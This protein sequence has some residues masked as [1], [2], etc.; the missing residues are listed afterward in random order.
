MASILTKH[1]MPGAGGSSRGQ[2]LEHPL[3]TAALLPQA[4][5]PGPRARGAGHRSAVQTTELCSLGGR[6]DCRLGAGPPSRGASGTCPDLPEV[7]PGVHPCVTELRHG[8]A[9]PAGQRSPAPGTPRPDARPHARV[10]VCATEPEAEDGPAGGAARTRISV[11]IATWTAPHRAPARRPRPLSERCSEWAAEK[12]GRRQ[13]RTSPPPRPRRP[14]GQ[15][16]G[17]ALPAAQPPACQPGP[18]PRRRQPR[19][20]RT[21][22]ESRGWRRDCRRQKSCCPSS[23]QTSGGVWGWAVGAPAQQPK[24]GSRGPMCL[25]TAATPDSPASQGSPPDRHHVLPQPAEEGRWGRGDWPGPDVCC[26]HG[27]NFSN[28]TS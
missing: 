6:G 28:L 23:P 15:A 11:V 16:S 27:R 24:E 21:V 22:P 12:R 17:T 18:L 19:S 14:R 20:T 2:V 13:P 25:G 1:P 4:S 7:R 26:F 9:P 8:S 5:R 10:P 3:S